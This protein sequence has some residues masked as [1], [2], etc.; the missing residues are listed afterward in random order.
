[1]AAPQPPSRKPRLLIGPFTQLLPMSGMPLKGP[2]PDSGLPV[3]E[4]A[5]LLLEGERIVKTGAFEALAREA[6]A[7]GTAIV[8][9]PGPSIGLPGFVDSHTHS[10][11][12]G[13]RAKDY[14]LRN[15][16]RTY[17]E[18]AAAGGG[19]WDSVQQT[20]SASPETLEKLLLERAGRFLVSGVTT[21]EVKSGYGLSV[22]EELKMLRVVRAA[23]AKT[24]ADLVAT[25][26][27][28]HTLPADFDGPAE[29]YL[30]I[31]VRELLPILKKEGLASRLDAFVE[32]SAFSPEDILPYFRAGKAMGF[33]LT[34]HADQ[35]TT[36]GSQV[37]IACGALSADHLEASG[38]KE[39]D[40]L[41]KS[42]VIATALPG[43]TLGLGCGFAPA[44]A[45]LDAGACLA[46][47]SDYNPG[48]APM[49]D[50]LTQAALLG[51]FEKLSHAEVLAGI[52]FRAAAALGLGDRGTLAGGQRADLVVFP[53]PHYNEILY[54][55]GQLRPSMVWKNGQCVLDNPPD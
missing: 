9:L 24:A 3:I 47:A 26:L 4:G 17:L 21:L 45:L 5:G 19:I 49:G 34:V 27:A 25:C 2:L 39:I 14:A 52:T 23:H 28:A 1:M 33:G 36:G 53:A 43:A 6:R 40:A 41:S 7:H 35:F 46:I 15:S 31:L 30:R 44:R 29:E 10:C 12:A 11:F 18:I 42:E 32:Q 50:L 54:R 8:E 55:Q 37:A 20:R 22:S 13:S 38:P 51:A 48:S 16:G